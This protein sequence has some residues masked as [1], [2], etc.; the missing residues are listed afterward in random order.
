[1]QSNRFDLLLFY[2]A[3]TYSSPPFAKLWAMVEGTAR[4]RFHSGKWQPHHSHALWE[5][6][7]T[8]Q[9]GWVPGASFF[10]EPAKNQPKSTMKKRKWMKLPH[11]SLPSLQAH[12]FTLFSSREAL[13]RHWTPIMT[14][15]FLG[16]K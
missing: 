5:A 2:L 11:C 8:I 4:G 7:S 13:L 1:V 10:E 9:C 15:A 16:P 3:M 12:A 6:K 14:L